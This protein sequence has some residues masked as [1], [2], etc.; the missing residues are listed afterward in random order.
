MPILH[1]DYL[2]Y[3]PAYS[4]PPD[5]NEDRLDVS[6]EYDVVTLGGY[7]PGVTDESK[8]P[9]MIAKSISA[10][11]KLYWLTKTLK[12]TVT[13]EADPITVT[14]VTG[15]KNRAAW[16]YRAKPGEW[17]TFESLFST[18]GGT[19]EWS[20]HAKPIRFYN[21]SIFDESNFIGYG[22]HLDDRISVFM[23][24]GIGGQVASL[25]LSSYD[26]EDF[27]SPAGTF[28]AANVDIGGITF[29]VEAYAEYP[30]GTGEVATAASLVAQSGPGG[31]QFLIDL[32]D[33][34]GPFEFHTI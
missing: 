23:I 22:L 21:G 1:T 8:L 30:G 14:S 31:S 34:D 2:G 5:P 18:A 28:D 26:T 33:N 25:S 24:D 16:Q 27:P 17:E 20:G 29:R 3:L 10:A 9:G 6:T 11:T 4:D 15:D 19:S 12:G 32:L 7:R 13:S